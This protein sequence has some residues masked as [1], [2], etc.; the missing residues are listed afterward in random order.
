MNPAIFSLTRNGNPIAQVALGPDERVADEAQSA[1]VNELQN[2]GFQV[3]DREADIEYRLW[4]GDLE[5]IEGRG[6]GP[7]VFWDDAAFFD[8]ARG[9]VWVHL[10]S[11]SAGPDAAWSLRARLPVYVTATKLSQQRYDT[12]MNQLRGLAAGLLFDLVS[13]MLRSLRFG[14]D[15]GGVSYRSSQV[16]LRLLER[17]WRSLAHALREIAEDPVTRIDRRWEVRES[18]GAGRFGMRTTAHLAAIGLDPRR[19][20]APRPF[21]ALREHFAEST[22]TVEH[23]VIAG[24]LLFLKDRIDSCAQNVRAHVRGIEEDRTFRQ[25]ASGNQAGL[26]ELEDMPRLQQLRTAIERADRLH[27]GIDQAQALPLLRGVQPRLS[28]PATPV[29]E[30]VRPYRR[31][32]DEFHRYLHSSLI[33]LEDGFDERLKST[34]RMYEQWV[35]FQLA[36]ALRNAGLH[37]T[38]QDGLFHRAQRFRYTLDL[39][40]GARLAFVAADGRAI[41][42]RFEPWVLPYAAAQQRGDSLYRGTRGEAAW[43]PDVVLEVLGKDR[44][45]SGVA[46]VE[47][48]VV[49]DAKYTTRI[50]E[51]HWNDT[52]KY[53]DIRA[54]RTKR[55]V[56]Y[57]LWLAY[58]NAEEQI[59]PEDTAITW[60]ER[61]PDCARDEFI[62]GRLGLIPPTEEATAIGHGAGWIAAAETTANRFVTGLLEFLGVA[63]QPVAESRHD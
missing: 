5:P 26:Y 16:E 39:D 46:E 36:A 63:P 28:L 10:A 11:R 17:L 29:F 35:F 58:P 38:T 4:L 1:I 62:W 8:G 18:W 57:Q 12:M 14:Q 33:L 43:S 49:V 60:T 24:L 2:C 34:Q 19:P 50:Q 9:R 15:Q 51:H 42:L 48:A 27:R 3:D 55:Q 44:D 59:E 21:R 52:R 7:T 41:M 23:R 53:R 61:G 56:V 31:I 54:T 13:P 37:C 30:H 45:E 47:Y 40:R 6:R 25:R 32:R 22:D 20:G